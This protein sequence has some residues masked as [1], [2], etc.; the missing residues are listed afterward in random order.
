MLRT[1]ILFILLQRTLYSQHGNN[2]DLSLPYTVMLDVQARQSN[3]NYDDDEDINNKLEQSG[4]TAASL[5]ALTKAFAIVYQFTL[6]STFYEY[7]IVG[8]SHNMIIKSVAN[9]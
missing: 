2:Y 4:W 6:L 9:S 7:G 1:F 8:N 5:L 3:G